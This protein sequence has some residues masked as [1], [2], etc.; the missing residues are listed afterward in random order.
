MVMSKGANIYEQ[1]QGK[2]N[3]VSSVPSED[4]IQLEH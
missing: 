2:T 3:K 1:V 4:S